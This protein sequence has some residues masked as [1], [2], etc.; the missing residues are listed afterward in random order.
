M[1]REL[2]NHFQGR[3]EFYKNPNLLLREITV[4]VV[5]QQY[6]LNKMV[7]NLKEKGKSFLLEEKLFS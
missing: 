5:Q 3:T 6:S 2:N 7:V 1:N 4:N